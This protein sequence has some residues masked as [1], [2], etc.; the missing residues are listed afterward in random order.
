MAFDLLLTCAILGAVLVGGTLVARRSQAARHAG[1][2]ERLATN[3]RLSPLVLGG[4]MASSFMSA[5]TPLLIAS[6]VYLDGLPG[7]WFWWISAPGVLA[8][9]F[10]FARLWRRS[11]VLTDVGVI[12][13]RYG[14]SVPARGLRILRA[15]V[16]GV[17]VN[18]LVMAS[19]GWALLLLLDAMLDHRVV[20]PGFRVSI[21]ATI[22]SLLFLVTAGFTATIGFRGLVKTNT[23]QFALVLVASAITAW[24]AV[25]AL[26]DGIGTLRRTTAFRSGLPVFDLLPNDGFTVA[27]LLA[28]LGWFHTAPGNGLLVQRVVAARD[29]KGA[30]ATVLTFALLHYLVRPWA[31]YL[32]GAAALYHVPGLS[33]ADRAFPETA[34]LVL[35]AGLA[36]LLTGG[37]LLAFVASVNTRLNLGAAYLVN[38]VVAPFRRRKGPAATR[39]LEVLTI[40]TLTIL[41]LALALGGVLGSFLKLYQF[42]IVISAGSAFVSIARWY[43]W[44]LTIWSE[45]ASLAT[46]LLLGGLLMLVGDTGRP[47]HFMAMMA[48]NF[49]VGA[50]VAIVL[51]VCGPA[52]AI[53]T[54]LAFFERVRPSGPG[55]RR[56]GDAHDD[57]LWWASAWWL[58]TNLLLF[59]AIFA[60]AAMLAGRYASASA[61]GLLLLACIPLM[62]WRRSRLSGVLGWADQPT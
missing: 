14:A 4:S 58:A 43:W 29:E 37:L 62:I 13:L 6:A 61:I 27:V 5:D 19:S 44:R 50:L 41:S 51:A 16:E 8:T 28:G 38:D 30:T 25:A 48:A 55:W 26:P 3:R 10:F 11:G 20:A 53:T 52:T 2:V 46:A 17:I 21:A 31:W 9:L 12:T 54:N 39:R 1:P 47:L 40:A 18:T 35:P 36:G 32:I 49:L 15:I 60:V 45:I 34:A 22:V 56:F 24:F 23:V 59:G 57:S 7:N 33:S 42:L